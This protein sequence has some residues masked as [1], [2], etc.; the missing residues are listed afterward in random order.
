MDISGITD[1]SRKVEKG[2][3]FVCVKGGSFDGHSFA[4][5]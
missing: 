5:K 3:L 4:E 1:D 2:S